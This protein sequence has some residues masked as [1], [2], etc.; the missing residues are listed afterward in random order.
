MVE[1][2]EIRF[3]NLQPGQVVTERVQAA[4]N[5]LQFVARGAAPVDAIGE[6]FARILDAP[7]GMFRNGSTI[8]VQ[9]VARLWGLL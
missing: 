6:A 4:G 5:E 7:A 3:Y 1:H 2:P 9:E 8:E